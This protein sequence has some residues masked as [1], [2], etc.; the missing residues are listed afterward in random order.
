M[1]SFRAGASSLRT[2]WLPVCDQ[3]SDAHASHGVFAIR[4]VRVLDWGKYSKKERG[5]KKDL[6]LVLQST[7]VCQKKTRND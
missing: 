2:S 7:M 3:S 4:H 5:R 1:R 6:E